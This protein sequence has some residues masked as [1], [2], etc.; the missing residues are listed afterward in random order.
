M[1]FITSLGFEPVLSERGNVYYNPLMNVQDACLAEVKNCQIL[2]LI[3]GGKIGSFYKDTKGSIT[4]AEYREAVKSKIPIFALVEQ[5][6][7][8]DYNLTLRTKRTKILI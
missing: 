4:N 7:F 5:E 3:I 8:T 6:V 1:S 2:L